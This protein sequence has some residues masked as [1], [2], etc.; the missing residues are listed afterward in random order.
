MVALPA[1]TI[2]CDCYEAYVLLVQSPTRA[3]VRSI[4]SIS[5]TTVV[6][7][8]LKGIGAFPDRNND[9]FRSG[10]DVVSVLH[11]HMLTVI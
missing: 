3:P 6:S 7:P 11:S 4:T 1:S 5:G 2:S 9:S 8:F 10:L